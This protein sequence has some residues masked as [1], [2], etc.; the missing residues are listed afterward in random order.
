M[1]R[2]TP[3]RGFHS[4]APHPTGSFSAHGTFR[5]SGPIRLH[6][7]CLFK[8]AFSSGEEIGI[9]AGPGGLPP[10]AFINRAIGV[11]A[12]LWCSAQQL[13]RRNGL[14][15]RQ[16]RKTVCVAWVSRLFLLSQLWPDGPRSG[17]AL[18][19]YPSEGR[20]ALPVRAAAF[21]GFGLVC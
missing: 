5:L 2:N 10:Q 20:S 21:P 12:P 3:D 6:E 7:R 14:E 9:F 11:A 1:T 17:T 4:S 8:M 15:P 19:F 18:G 13:F 16:T